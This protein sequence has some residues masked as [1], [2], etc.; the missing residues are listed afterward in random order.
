MQHKLLMIDIYRMKKLF[1]E[2]V[3][4][5]GWT[6]ILLEVCV[7]FTFLVMMFITAYLALVILVP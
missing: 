7:E 6:Y 2:K 4:K 5:K 3:N 1:R